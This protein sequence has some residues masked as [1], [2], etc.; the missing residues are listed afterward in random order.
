MRLLR[1]LV[2]PLLCAALVLPCIRA[3]A[4]GADSKPSIVGYVFPDGT[5]LSSCQVDARALTRIN[6][7]FA[8]IRNGA[9]V[10]GDPHD[11]A[12]LAL[13]TGLRRQ[14]PALTILLSV[15]GWSWSGNFS[16]AALTRE[17]RQA[18][19]ASALDLIQRYRLDGLDV[20][21]EYPDQSGAGNVHR[22][23]DKQ[24]FTL[25]LKAL[26]EQFDA[27]GKTLHRRLYLTIAA[28]ASDEY[29]QKTEMDK[30]QSY[31]DAVN[32][33]AYDFY[34]PGPDHITGNSAPLFTSPA[35]PKHA[36]A[37]TSIQAYE[38]AGVPAAKIVLGVPFYGYAWRD[39]ADV[40]HGLFQHGK[41]APDAHLSWD[42]IATT[43]LNHGFTRYWDAASSV[44][45]LY[46]PE[47]RVFLSYEDPQSLAAKSQYVL[48][49]KLAG[50]MFW[51]YSSDPSGTLLRAIN[52][53]LH[54]PHQ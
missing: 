52:D 23:E 21:W 5:S 44:P 50:I 27:A 41:S 30:V 49:N 8:N 7:A 33:M 17:S 39:V 13:L 16:D 51:H 2:L 18:F 29:L 4:A 45:Y 24:N 43:M 36:S 11:A 38:K 26:R 3:F 53:N 28:E 1:A 12:N 15:G 54:S 22:R 20:D 32:L 25:L 14:N 42:T 46:S 34:M 31:V 37:D 19:I 10:L 48:K 47:Q 9:V 6:Y 40:N 35:D